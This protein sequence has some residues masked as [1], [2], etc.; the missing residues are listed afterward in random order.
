MLKFRRMIFF[1][2]VFLMAVT[3]EAEIISIKEKPITHGTI[4]KTLASKPGPAG[5]S[6]PFLSSLAEYMPFPVV[7][8][9][10]DPK[11]DGV[12][13]D[14]DIS[15]SWFQNLLEIKSPG[16][17]FFTR[18]HPG[19]IEIAWCQSRSSKMSKS[20]P[21]I[22]F[23]SSHASDFLTMWHIVSGTDFKYDEDLV[24]NSDE[25]E[26][27]VISRSEIE[28]T[29]KRDEFGPYNY[30]RFES[31]D[32]L[33]L[34]EFM[35]K[36]AAR[37]GGS[38][39]KSEGSWI[40]VPFERTP[41]SMKIVS[42]LLSEIENDGH[43]A[44]PNSIEALQ[45][46]GNPVLPEIMSEFQKTKTWRLPALID[47]LMEI[48]SPERDE[49]FFKIAQSLGSLGFGHM[50]AEASRLKIFSALASSRYFPAISLLERYAKEDFPNS[51]VR[52]QARIALNILGRPLPPKRSE[53]V[54]TINPN[55][56]P[57][58]QSGKAKQLFPIAYAL[59]E[60]WPFSIPS[61]LKT[62][63]EDKRGNFIFKGEN[64]NGENWSIRIARASE[65]DALVYVENFYGYFAKLKHQNG[66]W[67]L[68]DWICTMMQ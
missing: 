20:V 67:L 3:A 8:W 34:N 54:M 12:N 33:P 39:R 57:I 24:K 46:I 59:L 44:S 10:D 49:A 38:V 27:R 66:R 35:A 23:S 64:K 62:A 11:P 37:L 48:P 26:R 52:F 25:W 43:L 42:D 28:L 4:S 2:F 1:A 16:G 17:E 6:G 40:F 7:I 56:S 18:N 68:C 32:K 55:V 5:F 65:N 31:S 29:V 60:Q 51:D 53:E 63:A 61:R 21:H 14:L 36:L 47:V 19:F 50:A 15:K 41:E 9:A 30:K 13:L 45:R 22:I 58:L